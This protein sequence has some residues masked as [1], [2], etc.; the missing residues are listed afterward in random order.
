[1]SRSRRHRG[2]RIFSRGETTTLASKSVIAI[3]LLLLLLL[4]C[5]PLTRADSSKW[6]T[7]STRRSNES[8]IR[9]PQQQQQ[10]D[11]QDLRADDA[12]WLRADD[13]DQQKII[14]RNRVKRRVLSAQSAKPGAKQ[15]EFSA[16]IGNVSAVLGRDVRL[17]CTVENL[18][19]HQV[20]SGLLV[21]RGAD[22]PL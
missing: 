19:Q 1:M 11:H 8:E 14:A 17:V 6:I 21:A 13:D 9:Q 22:K 7:A 18:G 5:I 20:S 15:P 12:S 4:F 16:P 10:Q 2:L 3:S